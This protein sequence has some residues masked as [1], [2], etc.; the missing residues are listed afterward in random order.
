[1]TSDDI[2]LFHACIAPRA[3]HCNN[4]NLRPDLTG[5]RP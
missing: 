2:F 1:M 3:L 5:D 4:F